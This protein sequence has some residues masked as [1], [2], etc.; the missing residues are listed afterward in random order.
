[1]QHLSIFTHPAAAHLVFGWFD[2]AVPNI[3]FWLAVVVIFAVFTRA[4]IPLFM[5]ADAASR[6]AE[7]GK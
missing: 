3:A 4:R 7:A 2:L 5:E 6:K 1:M